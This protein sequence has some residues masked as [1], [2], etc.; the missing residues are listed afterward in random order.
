[1]DTAKTDEPNTTPEQPDAQPPTSPDPT[2]PQPPAPPPRF[3]PRRRAA[4][5]TAI[6][7]A[8]AAALAVVL[9]RVTDNGPHHA[10]ASPAAPK[11]PVSYAVTGTGTAQITYTQNSTTST[12]ITA[13]LPWQHT[14]Q[15]TPGQTP[16]TL[17]ITLGPTGGR[18]TC[19][20]TLHGHPV[21]HA[22]A[23]GTYGRATCTTRTAPGSVL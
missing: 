8:A 4:L 19:T 15:L 23:Y 20:L 9:I 13:H 22:T 3:T 6:T 5:I 16:A 2:N 17:S 18:A 10:A 14:A 1:M 11:I 7:L 21:Q 12:T